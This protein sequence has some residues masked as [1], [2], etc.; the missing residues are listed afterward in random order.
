MS[1]S[2]NIGVSSFEVASLTLA[3]AAIVVTEQNS[4][5]VQ[6]SRADSSAG[7]ISVDVAVSG[8]AGAGIADQTIT[9]NWPNGVLG[10]QSFQLNASA[11]IDSPVSGAILLSNPRAVSGGAAN[12]TIEVG[13]GTITVNPDGG[14]SVNPDFVIFR[15]GYFM[16]S[17]VE[18]I[19][20]YPR[21]DSET[22]TWAKHRTHAISSA[23]EIPVGV[24]FGDGPFNYELITDC[25]GAYIG[26]SLPQSGDI[27]DWQNPGL[28]GCVRVEQSDLVAGSYSFEVRVWRQ[29]TPGQ[30]VGNPLPGYLSV[31]WTCNMVAPNTGQ[32]GAVEVYV[33]SSASPGGDGTLN[34]PYQS[35]RD[36]LGPNLAD[37][38]H[39]G[40]QVCFRG[41]THIAAL[42]SAINGGATGGNWVLNGGDKPLVYYG[43]EGETAI[44]DMTDTTI[45]AGSAGS[46]V[47][48]PDGSDYS[49]FNLT[50]IGGPTT[51]NNP[52]LHFWRG[53]ASGAAVYEGAS[54]GGSRVTFHK[55]TTRDF[56]NTTTASDNSGI[57]W[58]ANQGTSRRRHFI[59]VS[60]YRFENMLQNGFNNNWNGF[61]ISNA[62]HI[63][64]EF[65]TC[66][67]TNFG[68]AP[69]AAKSDAYR[70]CIRYVDMTQAPQQRYNFR[71][72]G[73]YNPNAGGP[74]E[75]SY[76]A[77]NN[78]GQTLNTSDAFAQEMQGTYS[79]S[80]PD[81]YPI[82][83][84]KSTFSRV[85]NT[86]QAGAIRLDWGTHI[87][88]CITVGNVRFR[89][90][91]PNQLLSDSG[92]HF[93]VANN[94]FDSSLQLT[95]RVT[96]LGLT[97][98]EI[99]V[100]GVES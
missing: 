83:L 93:T 43:M 5:T 98:H 97:G 39:A 77:C 9:L 85:P 84:D 35:I 67:N 18:P 30:R 47:S 56:N 24:M 49:M 20:V 88:N 57:F 59:Y 94:P 40:M 80:N 95:D 60:R 53:A 27:F 78:S 3:T 64:G 92:T 6:V 87:K 66:V 73:A 11:D 50:T 63:L 21:P 22:P 29:G 38:S 36:V 32:P 15:P 65:L 81:M 86:N 62:D 75:L 91:S 41:G 1:I 61:Y 34:N 51:R 23:Y 76:I 13:A 89:N 42:T 45:N 33:D 19:V 10:V 69:V 25:P 8:L 12:P 31:Q 54:S 44:L 48:H 72:A 28:Y 26:T 70:Y 52:R 14:A 74:I 90:A 82:V 99:A 96:L 58:C 17:D 2:A 37:T 55:V 68:R 71:T 46:T 16:E 79:A 7:A 100:A 4:F